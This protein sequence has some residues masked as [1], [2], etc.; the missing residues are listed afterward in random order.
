LSY[1]TNLNII[2]QLTVHLQ[3][4]I[5]IDVVF[6]LEIKNHLTVIITYITAHLNKRT[7]TLLQVI[8]DTWNRVKLIKDLKALHLNKNTEQGPEK[9]IMKVTV[10]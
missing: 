3:T 7:A 6:Q 9:C 5:K 8:R 1:I 2:I 4:S 10:M